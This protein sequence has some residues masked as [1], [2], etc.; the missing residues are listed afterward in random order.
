MSLRRYLPHLVLVAGTLAS[1]ASEP[2]YDAREPWTLETSEALVP[3]ILDDATPTN[4]RLL[5]ATLDSRGALFLLDGKVTVQL[6]LRARDVTGVRPAEVAVELVPM[7]AG[8]SA[9]RRIY[10]IP[11]GVTARVEL[12]VPALVGCSSL[13]CEERYELRLQRTPLQDDPI[14]DV[15]GS[16]AVD[17]TG[18]EGPVVPSDTVLSLDAADL[19]PVQ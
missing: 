2:A 1:I 3:Q 19:G 9:D 4:V 18:D 5:T 13:T 16:V 17:V 15:T 14:I 11:P 6:D 12:T 7:A 10:S 8:A